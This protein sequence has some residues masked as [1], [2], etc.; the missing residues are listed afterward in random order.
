M[1]HSYQPQQ[2]KLQQ[3]SYLS[4][5]VWVACLLC[6]LVMT[7]AVSKIINPLSAMPPLQFH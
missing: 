7:E 1:L 4:T 3:N 5:V 6:F 2:N